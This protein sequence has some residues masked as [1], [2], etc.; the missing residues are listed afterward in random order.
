[1]YGFSTDNQ[2][3]Y[4]KASK[5]FKDIVG[6]GGTTPVKAP[7]AAPKA[8]VTKPAPKASPVQEAP[9]PKVKFDTS[10]IAKK[11]QQLYK[12]LGEIETETSK[13]VREYNTLRGGRSMNNL[14]TPYLYNLYLTIEGLK[15]TQPL[16]KEIDEKLRLAG[17][18]ASDAAKY[19]KSRK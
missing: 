5:A 19:E 8:P 18:L 3:D 16:R 13:V 7:K 9:K 4:Y 17:R 1:M 2:K 14:E 6:A 15:Y 10:T 11:Y 12:L